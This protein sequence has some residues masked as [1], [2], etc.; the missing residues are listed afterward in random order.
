MKH[1][2]FTNLLTNL[3]AGRKRIRFLFAFLLAFF[4][5]SSQSISQ[6]PSNLDITF[7]GDSDNDVCQN[8]LNLILTVTGNNI[9]NNPNHITWY[10]ALGEGAFPGEITD[11][12]KKGIFYAH[13][14][15]PASYTICADVGPPSCSITICENMVVVE[16]QIVDLDDAKVTCSISASGIFNLDGLI[17]GENS[18]SNIY[19]GEWSLASNAGGYIIG[20]TLE[21]TS[22]GCYELTYDAPDTEDHSC[23]ADDETVHVFITQ[24]PQPNFDILDQIC[25]VEGTNVNLTPL[26]NSPVYKFNG[27][28][29]NAIETWTSS[30]NSIATVNGAGVVTIK[31]PGT[32]E[33][34]LEETLYHNS[35]GSND[36][37]TCSEQFCQEIIVI[38]TPS[39]LDIVL[40]DNICNNESNRNLTVTGSF[41]PTNPDQITWYGGLG[42]G[43]NPGDVSD[44]GLNGTFYSNDAPAGTYTICANVGH[45][46][47]M[48]T[49]CEDI[50][51]VEEQVVV[52]VDGAVECSISASG[53]FNLDGL[54]DG[55]SSS[56]NAYG[57]VWTLAPN[58]GGSIVGNSLQY[59]AAGCYELT[60][61][62]PAT[63]DDSCDESPKTATVLVTQQ[64][65]PSFD[66]QDQVCYSAGDPPA[67]HI[68][69]S[70]INSPD[71]SPGVD[72]TRT[73]SISS[74]PA[75]IDNN[76]NVTITGTGTVMVCLKETIAYD[77]CGSN[78]SSECEE[79][80][81]Q[82]ISV[83]DGTAQD[84]SFEFSDSE[85]CLGD[86]IILT[87]I[88]PGGEF[89]GLDVVDDGNGM[90]G[91]YTI[92]NCG[93]FPITYTLNN[94]NGCTA[95]YIVNL[96][97]DK[98]YPELT[99][100]TATNFAECETND[101]AATLAAWRASASATD[102]CPGVAVTSLLFNTISNCGITEEQVW[103]FT[104][105]DACGNT[106][107]GYGSF[108][109]V[110]TTDP[111]IDEE[112]EDLTVECDGSSNSP[113]L[114][115]W[116]NNHGGAE[117]SDI[118]GDIIWSHDYGVN[119]NYLSNL[120]GATGAVTVTFTATD[121]CGNA[122]STAADFI[123]EDTTEPTI[124]CPDDITLEC[125]NTN[126]GAIVAN[127]L[128]SASAFDVCSDIS[129]SNDYSALP[130]CGQ[131]ITITFNVEGNCDG[132][133]VTCTAT[134][135]VIDSQK[136]IIMVAPSDFFV[137]CDGSDDPNGAI[138]A[139]AASFGGMVAVDQCDP[140][141]EL[142][143][144][145]G[146][147]IDQCGGTKVIPYTFT[148]TDECG[149]LA[150]SEVAYA[151]IIDTT[152]PA[153][154][155]ADDPGPISCELADPLAWAASAV[156]VDFEAC[157]ETTTDY[158]L[159]NIDYSCDDAA[160][161][162]YLFTVMD[163][164]GNLATATGTYTT[165]DITNPVIIAP[166]DL[167][168]ECGDDIASLV[169][170]WLDDYTISDNCSSTPDIAV[171]N[172]FEGV[173]NLCGGSITVTW[174]AE[175]DCGNTSSAS[176]DIIVEDDDDGPTF[177]NCPDDLTVGVDVDEC[178]AYVIY[179]TPVAEDCNGVASVVLTSGIPSGNLFPL[180][181]TTI[182]FTATDECGNESIC[183]FDI[184]VVDTDDPTILCPSIDVVV[185]ADLGTCTWISDSSISPTLAIENCPNYTITYEI[186]G[187]TTASG[188]NDAAG[189]ILNLGTS[190]ISYTIMDANGNPT[191]TC[192]FNVIVEDCEAPT[193]N[194]YDELDVECGSENVAA[195]IA[196]IEAT[197]S[198]LC[199]DVTLET[200]LF[201]DISSCGNTIE[202]Q[203]LFTV[204]D[205]AGNTTTCIGT[206]ESDDTTEP[207]IDEAAADLTVECDGATNTAALTGW[208]NNHGGAEASDIC[209]DITWSHNYGVNGNFLSNLCGATGAVTVTFTATDECGNN[210]NTTASF[211]IEDTTE[212]IITCPED[213]TLECNDTNNGAIV[214]NWLNSASAFDVCSDISISNDYSALPACGQT[215]TITFT[216]EG[217]CDGE[218]VTC[219]ATISV[220]DSQKPVI[221]VAPADL[222]IECDGSDDPN[223]AIA[224]WA[225]TYG[226]MV[227]VDQC[228]PNPELSF[229]AGSAI[230]QCGGTKVIPYTFTATDECGN[231]A[232]SEVAYA[233]IIDT[234]DPVISIASDPGPIS[235]ELADPL[236]WAASAVTVDFEA[237]SE[238]TTDYALINID[239]SCDDAAVYTYLFTVTD[240]C[241]NLT[242]A[243]GT[244]T[245]IDETAP[246][247]IAPDDLEVECDDDIASMLIAW[248]DDY[249]VSDNCSA[250]PDISI[251][252]DFEELPD[253]C[254][255][256]VTVTWTAEDDCGNTSTA[257][258]EFII[259]EEDEG[260]EFINCPNDLT[261]GVDVDECSAY[262][263]YSTP[264]AVPECSEVESIVLTSGIPSGHIF[265]LGTTTII[266]TA[267]DECGNESTCEFDITVV[268]TDDP[269]ILCPSNDVVVCAD[270]GGCTWISDSS[271]APTLAIEN[272][273]NYTITYEIT[274]AT[275][276]SG[277][278][279]AA[280]EILNLGNSIISYTIMDANGNPTST[281]SFNVIVEDCEAPTILCYDEL[282]VECGSEDVAA[283]IAAIE[284]TA[285]DICSN[286]TV[287]TILFLDI[288]SCGNTIEQQYLFTVTDEAG[289]TTTC[290][291]TY[292]SDDTINPSIDEEA[293]DLTVE[294]DGATNTASLTGW[295]NNHGGAEASDICGEIT[296]SHNY[297]VNG[298]FLSN[299]CGVTGA[300]TVTF[301]ATDECGNTSSTS[302]TFT[303]EDT[304]DPI[305]SI[306]PINLTIECDGSTDPSGL[307]ADWLSINGHGIAFDDCGSIISYSNDYNEGDANTGGCSFW[308]GSATVTFTATDDCGN[309]KNAT[310]VVT[311]IDTTPPIVSCPPNIILNCN[312]PIP[313]PY[314]DYDA[315]VAA[316]G[317]VVDECSMTA[318]GDVITVS[319]LSEIYNNKTICPDDG[320]YTITR[321][322]I[323]TDAC[324]NTATCT[325]DIMYNEDLTPPTI[326]PGASDTTVDCNGEGNAAELSTWLNNHGG[327][328]A[329]DDC[330]EVTWT[331]D[332][333]SS[334]DQC[335]NT[336]I[337]T[338]RFT[339]T[340]GCGNYSTTDANFIIQDITPP[341]LSGG[342]NPTEEC[343]DFGGNNDV[344][345]QAWLSSNGGLTASDAC[346]DAINWSN[347]FDPIESFTPGCGSTGVYTVNFTATDDCG[348]PISQQQT[349]TIV[350]TTNPV[351]TNCP[352]PDVIVDAPAGW[353]AS[354]ANF[355]LPLATDNCSI[356]T[357]TQIDGT[358]LTSGSL[359][360][361]GTTILTWE[362]VDACGNS[363]TC[364][365]KVIV[366]DYHTPPEIVCPLDVEVA[367][368]QLMC[369][370]VVNDIALESVE[371]NCPDNLVI[372]YTIKDSNGDL[373]ECGFEDASGFKFPVG[374]STVEY[375]VQDQPLLLITE[376]SQ[377][378]T[379][380]QIEI[381]NFG[382]ADMDISCL[383][384]Q[385]VASNPAADEIFIV[386]N[387]VIVASGETY[388]HDF[389][390]DGGAFMVSC[391]TI[392]YGNWVI[393][394]VATN[395]AVAC[396]NFAGTLGSG[397]VYRIAVCD[398]DSSEDWA[399]IDACNMASIGI[400]NP[401]LPTLPAN[402]TLSS[403]QSEAP[404]IATCSFE[405]TVNDE[406]DPFC[407]KHDTLD[408]NVPGLPLVINGNTACTNIN[409]SI[410]SS[411]IV[412][413]V[414]IISLAG[415]YPDMGALRF[416]LI[417][418]T[419]TEVL[420][421][422][423]LCAGEADFDLGLDDDATNSVIDAPCGLLGFGQDYAPVGLLKDFFGEN[424][425]GIWTLEITS[426][427]ADIGS[428]N[429]FVLE[430]NA[431][432]AYVPE[433]VVLPN[434]EGDCGANYTWLHPLVGDNC[435]VGA[436]SVEYTSDDADCIPTGGLLDG[437]GGYYVTEFF[438]VGTT[439]VTYSLLDASGNTSTCS[440]EVTVEDQENPVAICP[441]DITINL[442]AG[443]CE[444]AYSF[445]ITGTDNCGIVNSYSIPP[446]GTFFEIGT[447]PVTIFVEDEAGNVNACTFNVTVQ[448]YND[449]DPS[450]VCNSLVNLSLDATCET[451]I[452]PDMILE[453]GP[454]TCY[455]NYIVEVFECH[456]PGCD[457]IASS[458]CVTLE[459]IGQTLIVE[460]TDPI[461]G[462]YCWGEVYIEDKLI[463]EVECPVDTTINCNA[464]TDP[465]FTGEPILLS[466]EASVNIEYEDVYNDNGNCGDPRATIERTWTI[467]DESGNATGCV[468]TITIEPFDLADVT[469]PDDLDNFTLP[470]L[471]CSEVQDDPS[472]TDPSNTGEPMINGQPL[473]QGGLCH[474]STNVTDEIYDVCNNSYEILRT[475][476]VRNM[477]LPLGPNNPLEHTQIIKVLDM[478]P[479]TIDG[480]LDGIQLFTTNNSCS[481]EFN[482]DVDGLTVTD[483]CSGVNNISVSSSTGSFDL[484]LGISTITYTATDL[485]GNIATCDV[486]VEVVD[487][488]PPV[489]ICLSS[490]VV[491]LTVDE[492]L[493]VGALVFDNGSFDNC[494]LVSYQ[495]R[496]MDNPNC[497]GNDATVFGDYVPFYCCDVNQNGDAV[498]VE[499]QVTDAAGNTNSCMI[500]VEVQDKLNPAISCPPNIVLDCYGDPY[501]L[502]V[503]GYAT[504]SD[505]CSAIVSHIDQGSIDNCGEG[506]IFRIWTATDPGGRTASCVQT[507]QVVNSDPFYISDNNC[508]N[509]DPNDG[510]IWPCDYETNTCDP[511][512]APDITGEPT[513]I[514]DGC[515]LIA[516]TYEDLELPIQ[517]PAC[518]KILRTWIVIDWCQYNSNTGEGYWE[519]NQI[520][521]VLN[522]DDPVIISDCQTTAFC[523]Y[524]ADCENG[525]ATLFLEATDD[526]TND[527][528]LNYY[529]WIDLYS[530]GINEIHAESPDASGT[531]PLGTHT[532]RWDVEDGCGN[533][534]TCTY[535]FIISDCKAPTPILL[536]G[537]ATE[538]M[539]NCTIE[540]W[541]TDWDDPSSPS[542]DNCGIAEWLVQSPS[543]GPGQTTPPATA[544]PIWIFNS[545]GTQTV[546]IWILD[547]NGNWAYAS[548]YVL[549]ENNIGPDCQN[550]SGGFQISGEISNE[551]AEMVEDVKVNLAGSV[552]GIPEYVIT[553]EYGLYGFPNLPESANY[554]ITP[555][556]NINPLNGVSTFDLILIT[557]HILNIQQL[558]SPYKIIAADI[559]H[560]GTVTAFDLVHLRKLILF[561]D[562]EF[563]ENTS[564]RFVD[565]D[566]IFPNP[567]NPFESSFP[568]IFS[569]NGLDQDKEA[570]F[571]GVKIG[572]VNSSAIPNSL[573][574][575]GNT[576]NTVG[577]L[578]FHLADQEL[579]P[580]ENYELAFK[581]SDFNTV[582]G[583]QFT[584]N[585]DPE[586]IEF[587][588]FAEGQ[589]AELSEQNFG[590]TMLEKGVITTSWN[591]SEPSSM[592]DD[593]ILF[594]LKFNAKK[595]GKLS[596][597]ISVNSRY[598]KAEAYNTSGLL[599]VSLRF[600]SED[601]AIV[602]KDRFELYQNQP[603]PFKDETT[604]GFYLP[605][606]TSGILTIYDVSGSEV[607]T[608]KGEFNAGYN[609]IN[610]NRSELTGF[611][612]LY[613]R[614]ATPMGSAVK[615]M[616][617]IR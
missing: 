576:R 481:A 129:I 124:T 334:L 27:H 3:I 588:S 420:L 384:I 541:A 589:L 521:K 524:D 119:G 252:N 69:P 586:L 65:Q 121:E 253:I 400:L 443:E 514:E 608:F 476:K 450:L 95:S 184:T 219:S 97:T 50:I 42:Q 260:P 378:G 368:D 569:V 432:E 173:P 157:S 399:I 393:D 218:T 499:L 461:S 76:G 425:L 171:T 239:Y 200:I 467:T 54:I 7:M 463:P 296:W 424:A 155:I 328:S 231:L 167:H 352:A 308:T 421:F 102:N 6:C 606:A 547:V 430:V 241:G 77:A 78:A 543:Q 227:A 246:V 61:D 564:W 388:V 545:E 377:S 413:D 98:E 506:T 407:A 213:I 563:Q 18:S 290:I 502:D 599:D 519:Y 498:M 55:G 256:S 26:V 257:S 53:I 263:I 211:I 163:E 345:L 12:G 147:A 590:F 46:E 132:E 440:F 593:K 613:Y 423:G 549:V 183:E 457:P 229:S 438:C 193:I 221:M 120:C 44:N 165:Q 287:E 578:E 325:Q 38:P 356:P 390:F 90:T 176:A 8:G 152:D 186:S 533:V 72:L 504:A 439:T 310:A 245:T 110:D 500:E 513:I 295:L 262:V 382:P 532:I 101:V 501:D 85:F 127:W 503:T 29:V 143:F 350:D 81:C 408:Y 366:N 214:A 529:Y 395:G 265:P 70:K 195:W 552:P 269:T 477:C 185:C 582:L 304:T 250:T 615:T 451:C 410:T 418:P 114:I 565:A 151:H 347:D 104:A 556:K 109:I 14:A 168:V 23:D 280:G 587:N 595:A 474:Y 406:E 426:N 198:D 493:Y 277:N 614:L 491:G 141:P 431:L 51:V 238:T 617:I 222:Y 434:D 490:H 73:W 607:K 372:T 94:P 335:S 261:V 494:E 28:V 441:P 278:N 507:I 303:I 302:A 84:A 75:T 172:D 71:Y 465:S 447:T 344:E 557:K 272:C 429:N 178:A 311:I 516:V 249:I 436:I 274:G 427:S 580:G 59:N 58:A 600:E 212:P 203:Y 572:D 454:Y 197:A 48:F 346:S 298:N 4:F 266:F 381:T 166:E 459:N 282:D 45:P 526:C 240:E 522:S 435:C 318:D 402:S 182:I 92:T 409:V 433:N 528:D 370:A 140:N 288:S 446:S 570:D 248:L 369:G 116:L 466:C 583:Y 349:F 79:T 139:W 497:P 598:T 351:F 540:I 527:S 130:A 174:T 324:G 235:C 577:D 30:D 293:E 39:D 306:V 520:I 133:T 37:V 179:S 194:C 317:T 511:G 605:A 162:T 126:N 150:I 419:G 216:V 416:K 86:V 191:S 268:D 603:N 273:P 359:F 187:A 21:Y 192:S 357:V 338:Y 505:N 326:D 137:E 391:F 149:N 539:E 523:S 329:T 315:F 9:P 401:G 123:I 34:C 508:F 180:G 487:A 542:F 22:A 371:D 546:D 196:A 237:C 247:I 105:T 488:T 320:M 417:S 383:V 559:N 309:F 475:F 398:T 404:S 63:L 62:P 217:N 153:I 66:I 313:D 535:Q 456:D 550:P 215:V 558:D 553:D 489:P 373:L 57:G 319:F 327:A 96:E 297:G 405:V 574:G 300:V 207:S 292:E 560:S 244:Y 592:D 234:T 314:T 482:P 571:I 1:Q 379:T 223:G 115:G 414:N 99:L 392:S 478:T 536:N 202:Q 479:P 332:L 415:N 469:F 49:I 389:T 396:S 333:I 100:P 11:I 385:R 322:Y 480:C 169:V 453:G 284:A 156:T 585:F 233:H 365:I 106:T 343:D 331:Y 444:K 525:E 60:Y 323:A 177:I 285:S 358:G 232:I 148:A 190:V 360:P 89:T 294:C 10:G 452:T 312:D 428:L 33:I 209:G 554:T 25:Y 462:N 448:E 228:D 87:A 286:V 340:D 56:S 321:T 509:P 13:G 258:A 485:C 562:N 551:E 24:Q 251:T 145:A 31:G 52:L 354:F 264:V 496:R 122:S 289:N 375:F 5:W 281:C 40:T 458:P 144:S 255:G 534:A 537:I 19:G 437:Q 204:T 146:S 548:T 276:A 510:V 316:G 492:P 15:P 353:C 411:Y 468:Q 376:T 36:A 154:S 158:A 113:S 442:D 584:L 117:A 612:V 403:L 538:L 364:F 20:N 597:V 341:A 544:A 279:N 575:D 471:E 267:T 224:A 275:I 567:S 199:G 283:W 208:L 495:V 188:N 591:T 337:D 394:E 43:T 363:T 596:D 16:E 175:D 271:I 566:F 82:Q 339:A 515:D 64:P 107:V 561:I 181:A 142:S 386:P 531:Y 47:C 555:E 80:F 270:L 108:T 602:K 220:I 88:T 307:I 243:F 380:D 305:W 455:D 484:P 91:S 17:D 348:N 470:A 449:P 210:S 374:T 299:L 412:G 160:I 111:S 226:G 610:I 616:T 35:C 259:E 230:D 134:I 225:A 136:P 291:A 361:V 387:G 254:G 206:Y 464:S 422:E 189:E 32:V 93:S 568:E 472:L 135:S 445:I 604:V 362:A 483:E 397:D 138:A 2:I 581:A 131:T 201:L 330:S 112:A 342:E 579:I 336:V 512:L 473:I 128:N 161:Y 41:I 205:E 517:D 68:Y 159:I 118:C 460:I 67:N 103:E 74:G 601:G 236:A 573:L 518:L 125:N 164:C 301:T 355:S 609:E 242:T 530:N 170:A 611:G 594:T 486:E 367:N 83:S